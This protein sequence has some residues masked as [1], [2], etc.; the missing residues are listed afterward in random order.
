MAQ[1]ST[2][3]S[4]TPHEI[5]TEH[6]IVEQDGHVLTVTLNRPDARNALSPSMMAAMSASWDL[7]NTDDSIRVGIVTGAGGNFCAG[8]DLK[9]LA[10][11]VGKTVSNGQFDA[12]TIKPLL[13]GFRVEKPLIAAVEGFA[14]AGG[15]ELLIGTDIRVAG[16]S[17]KFGLA[18]P[19]WGLYPMGGS[20]VRLPRQV[21]YT[22]AADWL[23]TGRIF[24]ADEAAKHGLLGYV[25]DDGNALSTARELAD[26][27]ASN[28]P[29]PIQAI[30]KVMRD[31]EGMHEEE[32]FEIDAALGGPIFGTDDAIEGPTAFAEKRAPKFT[33]R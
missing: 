18:E 9:A 8:M 4:M 25:T 33:G 23:L 17:A 5:S 19:K 12:R 7:I 28:G 10:G 32:A 22:V 27:I 1:S 6:C 11:G 21:P 29:L 14:V 24:G 16:R 31:T 26:Q 2:L 30:M 20:A 3:V 13:K 15:T